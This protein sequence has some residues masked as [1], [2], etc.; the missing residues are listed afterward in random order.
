MSPA[1]CLR[2]CATLMVG[3]TLL[4]GSP[5]LAWAHTDSPSPFPF[6]H[7]SPYESPAPN[8]WLPA[9]PPLSPATP[10]APLGFLSFLLVASVIA[11]GL[12]S[13][14][15]TAA[16]TLGLLLGVFTFGI[17]VHSVHHLSEP[18]KGAECPVFF[19]SQHVS[20]TPTETWDLYGPPLAV[21]RPPIRDLEAPTWR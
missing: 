13:W 2:V 1:G 11:E 18:A 14:R 15:K 17:A 5:L 20:G 12:G 9:A 19:A 16:V 8:P 4:L 7:A 6:D 21:I 10:G 3:L